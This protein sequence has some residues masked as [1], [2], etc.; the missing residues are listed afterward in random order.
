MVT[1]PKD[2]CNYC[3]SDLAL[4][5]YKH[6]LFGDTGKRLWASQVAQW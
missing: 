5:K 1:F 2:I 4:D 6:F 3:L